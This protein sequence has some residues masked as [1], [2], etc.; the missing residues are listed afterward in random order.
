MLTDDYTF[1]LPIAEFRERT[2]GKNRAAECY[3]QIAAANPKLKFEEPVRISANGN[4]VVIEFEDAGMI[5]GFPYRNRITSSFD[6][7]GDQICGYREYFG[8][9]DLEMLINMAQS[10]ETNRE[11]K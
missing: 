1:C 11:V 2:V 5:M 6:V 7:R 8:Y 9:L 3:R 4:T 10:S